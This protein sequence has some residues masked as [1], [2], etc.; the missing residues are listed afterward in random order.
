M[1]RELHR[2]PGAC[3]TYATPTRVTRPGTSAQ[4]LCTHAKCTHRSCRSHGTLTS[5]HVR[6][7]LAG[8]T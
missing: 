8:H 2:A 4:T 5:Q 6:V 7:G 1:A 3:N